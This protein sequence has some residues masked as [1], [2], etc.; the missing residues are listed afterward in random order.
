MKLLRAGLL[1]SSFI[2][3]LGVSFVGGMRYG[4]SV[5][6]WLDLPPAVQ[7][8]LTGSSTE[9]GDVEPT[10]SLFWEAW[11]VVTHNYV[12]KQA[13]DIKRMTWG[14]IRGMVD[15]LGDNGHSRF[16]NPPSFR[17]EQSSLRGS[18][19]GI[20]AEV[21]LRNNQPI[22]VAPLEGGPAE[23]AGLKA[24]DSIQR[25]NGEDVSRSSLTDL[26]SKLRG[27][28]NTTVTLTV[29]HLNTELPVDVTVR[30]ERVAIRPVTSYILPDSNVADIKLA[31]FSNSATNDLKGAL[32][33]ALDAHVNGVVLDL[34]DNPGGLLNQAVDVASEFMSSGTVVIVRDADGAD[35]TYDV[36][37]GGLATDVPLTVLINRGTASAA[38]IVAGALA[39]NHRATVV[40]QT[41]Y[42]TG[43]VLNTFRLKDGS[44]IL[45][46]TAQWLTPSGQLI[47]GKG[48]QPSLAV[49][50]PAQASI[51][52]P[53][54]EKILN[55]QEIQSS[56]DQQL[57][58]AVQYLLDH[59]E[60]TTAGTADGEG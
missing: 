42:G 24:G 60:V 18:F 49:Q 44:G 26:M 1:S 54:R 33:T 25:V 55:K 17:Q 22:I 11:D 2:L 50:L 45:L 12:D 43:T 47:K 40:G 14:A 57:L 23:Q 48:I 19:I 3:L 8:Q 29:Q 35:R 21:G 7:A 4:P 41:S 51:L 13:I 10:F 39:D 16:L 27:E 6:G 20:G 34:R 30:R 59:T 37:A 52:T 46:G 36:K 15:S 28:A 31:E 53:N 32:K 38:E 58:S 9:P 5:L 56:G